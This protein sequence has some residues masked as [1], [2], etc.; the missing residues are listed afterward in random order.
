MF[1]LLTCGL[2]PKFDILIFLSFNNSCKTGTDELRFN[3]RNLSISNAVL[4]WSDFPEPYIS[5]DSFNVEGNDNIVIYIIFII[6]KN[7]RYLEFKTYII[8]FN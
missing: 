6:Y 2:P 5:L 8:I 4:Y 7:K 3:A 1:I